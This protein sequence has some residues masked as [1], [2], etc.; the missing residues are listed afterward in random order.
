VDEQAIETEPIAEVRADLAALGLDSTRAIAL[1]RRLAAGAAT[2]AVRLLGRIGEAEESDDEIG[3]L[4]KADIAALRRDLAEGATAVAIANAQ[5]AAGGQSAVVG[6]RR[7]RPRRRS[8]WRLRSCS[9]SAFRP[10]GFN[11][12]SR[13]RFPHRE[14]QPRP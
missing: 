3:W 2:P 4:E 5:R 6:L 9:M 1:A 14:R 7:R 13:T 12:V 8:R 11:T 10:T